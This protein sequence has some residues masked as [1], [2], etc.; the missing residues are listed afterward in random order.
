MIYSHI[1]RR[2]SH[3]QTQKPH[4]V[5]LVSR[6]KGVKLRC[7]RCGHIKQRYTKEK[8]TEW[9][10]PQTINTT[11]TTGI[12]TPAV[13]KILSSGVDSSLEVSK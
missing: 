12:F 4:S 7:S 10:E 5:Y 2:C 13:S 1:C 6:L 11:E 3:P 8:L 9:K